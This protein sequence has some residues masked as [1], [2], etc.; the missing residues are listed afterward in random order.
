MS[1]LGWFIVAGAAV[2]AVLVYFLLPHRS[3]PSDLG[4]VSQ[5]WVAHHRADSQH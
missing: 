1:A 2:L 3:D 4:T 5:Q